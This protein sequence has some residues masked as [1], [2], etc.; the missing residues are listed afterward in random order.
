MRIKVNQ[1]IFNRY[2]DEVIVQCEDGNQYKAIEMHSSYYNYERKIV[3]EGPVEQNVVF[4]DSDIGIQY[5]YNKEDIGNRNILY[6]SDGAYYFNIENI[7]KA[8]QDELDTMGDRLPRG[9]MMFGEEERQNVIDS[10]YDE[11]IN[12]DEQEFVTKHSSCFARMDLDTEFGVGYEVKYFD[13]HFHDKVYLSKGRYHQIGNIQIVNWRADIANLYYAKNILYRK[14]EHYLDIFS[15]DSGS[16]PIGFEYTYSVMLRRNFISNPYGKTDTYVCG[17]ERE[18]TNQ[19]DNEQRIYENGEIDS[20]LLKVL[21]QKRSENKLTDIIVS[22][23]ANQNAIIRHDHKKSMIVQGCAGSGKTMILLHRISYLR[24]NNLLRNLRKAVMI[25]PNTQFNLF[26]DEVSTNL[27]IEDMPR[28]TMSEYYL[29]L[30]EKYQRQIYV[31]MVESNRPFIQ[32]ILKLKDLEFVKSNVINTQDIFESNLESEICDFYDWQMSE[33][34]ENIHAERI[35]ELAEQFNIEVLNESSNAHKLNYLNQYIEKILHIANEKTQKEARALQNAKEYYI[36][37][38]EFKRHAKNIARLLR[39][40]IRECEYDNQ[41]SFFLLFQKV[42]PKKMLKD[43]LALL[44]REAESLTDKIK[45]ETSGFLRFETDDEDQE[46]LEVLYEQIDEL[47]N[48]FTD[49]VDTDEELPV[50]L[51]ELL[52][53]LEKFKK[54]RTENNY[55][56]SKIDNILKEY[57]LIIEQIFYK[58]I[59]AVEILSR[60]RELRKEFDNLEESKRAKEN[61]EEKRNIYKCARD[62]VISL[63]DWQ[64]IDYAH[65][66][67]KNRATI[68]KSIFEKFS[69]IEFSR[70]NSAWHLFVILAMYFLHVGRISIETDFVFVDEA[71]DYS[72]IEYRLLRGL[73]GKKTIIELYGDSMQ[74]ITPNRGCG[75]WSQVKLLCSNEYYELKE[76]YRNTIE[77]A[78]YVNTHIK[79]V[80]RTIGLHGENVHELGPDWRKMVS[81]EIND[82]PKRRVAVICKDEEIKATINDNIY[83]CKN[84]YTVIEAKGLEFD[85]VYVFDKKMTANEK[86]I[87]CSRALKTLNIIRE[88]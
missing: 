29:N 64:V 34:L 71:Q 44:K 85:S 75:N 22:I 36:N 26:I 20:F 18:G 72:D 46:K 51:N 87:A 10:F 53:E 47:E 35:V 3:K 28:Y 62:K 70:I 13:E 41:K 9:P 48:S 17:T 11:K 33:Y 40:L 14:S 16:S 68:V 1:K 25:V 45:S 88:Y 19:I 27:E 30:I 59:P 8:F 5:F 81:Q 65:K 37:Y 55:I 82:Y 4:K 15:P 23:Q 86:Y 6:K 50:T 24:Y 56:T 61:V 12:R 74:K 21:E 32:E 42:C 78:D 83:D 84:I 66:Q 43:K 49:S 60:L 80:F 31:D 79:E 76:N 67:L 69:D 63:N 39:T 52:K 58:D 73:H 77:I 57:D 7:K 38:R 54:W 2:G